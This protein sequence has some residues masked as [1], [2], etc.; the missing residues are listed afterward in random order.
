MKLMMRGTMVL[1]VI[2]MALLFPA[3]CKAQMEVAPDFYES[4]ST[5]PISPAQPS[6]I[7]ASTPAAPAF[8]GTVTL[9]YKVRVAGTKLAA[10]E[11]AVSVDTN[12]TAR[13]ITL[14]HKGEVTQLGARA[15][16]RVHDAN[17]SALLI[18][19]SGRERKL[20]AVYVGKLNLVLYLDAERKGANAGRMDRVPI[21]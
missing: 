17:P 20:G 15:A 18:E 8:N 3:A 11:Y 19:T 13:P 6:P 14:R 7:A 12:G 9:P 21:S 16:L 10:G 2:G 4:A 5:E 1:A